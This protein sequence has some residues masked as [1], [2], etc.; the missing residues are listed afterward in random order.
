[1]NHAHQ[2]LRENRARPRHYW[3]SFRPP[4][5]YQQSGKPRQLCR[6]LFAEFSQ[7]LVRARPKDKTR[8]LQ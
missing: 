7:K 2:S 6:G 3:R 8:N 1:M 4:V 5:Y